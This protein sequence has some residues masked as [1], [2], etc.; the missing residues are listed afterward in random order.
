MKHLLLVFIFLVLQTFVIAQEQDPAI[1][2]LAWNRYTTENFV[3]NSIDDQQGKW[4]NDNIESIKKWCTRRWGFPDFEFAKECRIF[5]VPDRVLLKKLFNLDNSKFEI[6][7]NEGRFE[8]AAIWLVLDDKPAR[9]IPD[10][11]SF[12]CFAEFEDKYKID[13]PF[14]A[15]NGMSIINGT[16]PVIKSY[17]SFIGEK[18]KYSQ[19]IFLSEAIFSM[20]EQ[21]YTTLSDENKKLFDSQSVL[22]CLLLR[23][24]FGESKLQRFYLNSKKYDTVDLLKSIY[25]F[26]SFSDLDKSMVRFAKDLSKDIGQNKTPDSYLQVDSSIK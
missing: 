4:M 7:K 19:K 3:I 2:D 8:I 14:F 10:T 1:K 18:V 13:I 24:E 12:I 15:K 23:K 20:T 11:L 26:E 5:C 22:M 6:R 17:V 16:I 9:V 21:Q 25:G